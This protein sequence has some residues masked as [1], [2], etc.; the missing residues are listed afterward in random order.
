MGRE[1]IIRAFPL[2]SYPPKGVLD[3]SSPYPI[4]SPRIVK[5]TRSISKPNC[6]S[7]PSLFPPSLIDSPVPVSDFLIGGTMD[8]GDIENQPDNGSFSGG[9]RGREE[10][11]RQEPSGLLSLLCLTLKMIFRGG[12]RDRF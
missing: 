6:D 2:L 9:K 10:I 3:I 5:R 8:D 4:P 7:R 12:R 1:Q 11:R